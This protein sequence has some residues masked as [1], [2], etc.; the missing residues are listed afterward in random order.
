MDRSQDPKWQLAMADAAAQR[1]RQSASDAAGQ[2]RRQAVAAADAARAARNNRLV[3]GVTAKH[4]KYTVARVAYALLTIAGD[5]YHAG[6]PF[7]V[8]ETVRDTGDDTLASRHRARR[9]DR[10]L[11]P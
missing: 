6:Q 11:Y 5:R 3:L 9:A 7:S 4:W 8:W 1:A 10:I 2:T